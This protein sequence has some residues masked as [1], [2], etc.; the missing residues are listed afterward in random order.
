MFE[1]DYSLT[2][3]PAIDDSHC[4]GRG[5]CDD[6]VAATANVAKPM[7][8]SQLIPSIAA[9]SFGLGM[10]CVWVAGRKRKSK[11]T[12]IKEDSDSD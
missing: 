7:D 3:F 2:A 12:Q 10:C 5:C 1:D 8:W 4:G 11:K 9:A 6:Q